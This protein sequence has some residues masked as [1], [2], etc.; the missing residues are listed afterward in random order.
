MTLL[1]GYL[2]GALSDL[3]P[4]NVLDSRKRLVMQIYAAFEDWVISTAERPAEAF[5]IDHTAACPH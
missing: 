1:S 3:A 4:G 5:A 2:R